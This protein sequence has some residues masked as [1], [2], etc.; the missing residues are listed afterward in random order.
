[1][2]FLLAFYRLVLD[3]RDCLSPRT[4]LDLPSLPRDCLS[5]ATCLD[6]PSLPASLIAAIACRHTLA[7]TYLDLPCLAASSLDA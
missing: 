3:R 5:P 7:S 4:C 6:L 1:M 2:G